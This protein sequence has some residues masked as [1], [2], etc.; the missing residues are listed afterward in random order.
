MNCRCE[1]CRSVLPDVVSGFLPAGRIDEVL[2]HVDECPDCRR[3]LEALRGDDGL[4]TRY[5]V[6]MQPA[7]AAA[8]DAAVRSVQ[9]YA[10]EPAAKVL[11]SH[12][13]IRTAR[14]AAAAVVVLGVLGVLPRVLG[15]V[16]VSTPGLAGTLKAMQER[17]WVSSVMRVES[18]DGTRVYEDWECPGS[19]IRAT[20]MPNGFVRYTNYGKN[21]AYSYNPR[22][23]KITV[24]FATDNYMVPQGNSPLAMVSQIVRSAQ[25]AGAAVSREDAEGSGPHQELIRLRFTGNPRCESVTLIRDAESN[26][27]LRM[28]QNTLDGAKR[29]LISTTYSYPD[30]GPADVYALGVPA[31]AI[32][33]DTRPEGPALLLVDKIQE[34]FAR[35]FGDHLAVI[36]QSWVG[37]GGSLDPV[38]IAVLRQKGRLKRSDHYH[39]FDFKGHSRASATLYPCVKDRWPNLTI[40]QVLALETVDAVERR[41]LFDGRKTIQFRREEDGELVRSEHPTDQFT[42]NWPESQTHSLTSLIWPNLHLEIQSGS[43]QYKREVRLLGEDP[44]RPGLIGLQFVRFAETESLWFDPDRDYMLVDRSMVRQGIVDQSRYRVVQIGQTPSGR[45][46]PSVARIGDREQ[47]V[48][49]DD[50]PSFDE[51]V[52]NPSEE[53][54]PDP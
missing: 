18:A 28:D 27:L 46:Y 31:D 19:R 45:W 6:A 29:V 14:W 8:E 20:K 33:F 35:G 2:L 53:T 17:S 30:S 22:S 13:A 26:L 24:G 38:T 36:L 41:M 4:L 34:R 12:V 42:L 16:G 5:T 43:S 1:E 23:H 15:P 44:N 11:F 40:P 25:Q 21:V 50:N 51:A 47:R 52:F 3:C 9:Q 7:I 37:D 10:D 49:V 48:L 54:T 32:I 39:A